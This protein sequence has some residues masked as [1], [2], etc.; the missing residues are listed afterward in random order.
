M[1]MNIKIERM[2]ATEP[3][4]KL[5]STWTMEQPQTLRMDMRDEVAKILQEEIDSEI[6]ANLYKTN[7]WYLVPRHK[8][9]HW[10]P[11]EVKPWLKEHCPNGGYHV[12][13]GGCLFQD[14]EMAVEF[15]LT[16]T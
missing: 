3:V 7:G 16:W 8:A 14:Q 10:N 1:A 9:D 5:N 13:S 12:W 2:T 4:R 11:D 6:L 15:E